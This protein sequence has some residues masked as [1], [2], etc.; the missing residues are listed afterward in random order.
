MPVLQRTS[1]ETLQYVAGGTLRYYTRWESGENSSVAG[2]PF[3]YLVALPPR[4]RYP[5]PVG[6]HLHAW[7]GSLKSELGWWFNAEK[8]A[9]L[10]SSNQEPYDWWTGYHEHRGRRALKTPADWKAGVIRPYSQ[11]RMLSFVDWLATVMQLD[12]SRMFVAGVSMGGSGAIM[13]ALRQPSRIAW[14]VSW[15]GVHVPRKSPQ[16][17]SAYELV[18]GKPE[19]KVLFEDGTPVWDYFD[20]VQY[21]RRHPDKDVGFITFA[22]GKT[23]GA[24]GWAPAVEF[25]RALQETRQPHMFVWGQLGHGQRAQMPA[26]GGERIMPL[27]L[28]TNQSLPAF[29]RCSLDDDPGTG[30][31]IIRCGAGAGEPV[32]DMAARHHH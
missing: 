10:V 23:D 3:D 18:Y 8:G 31:S 21:L 5:A 1:S 26:N 4:V 14:T 9:V 28:R 20:D 17:V 32:P 13:L 7:G 11:K 16:F 27:D 25:F 22:N 12:L 15:V 2:K 19:W 6:L 29:T 24:I 30:C